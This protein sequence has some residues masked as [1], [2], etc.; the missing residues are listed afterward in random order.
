MFICEFHK[1][2]LGFDSGVYECS[3]LGLPTEFRLIGDSEIRQCSRLGFGARRLRLAASR[4][5]LDGS[6][7][8][9]SQKTILAALDLPEPPRHLD[10]NTSNLETGD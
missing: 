7:T 8:T 3:R 9:N 10:F 5:R 2:Y 4:F 6:Q 1:I